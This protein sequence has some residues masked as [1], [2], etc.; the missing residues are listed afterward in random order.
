MTEKTDEGRRNFLKL[1][2]VGAPAA[3]AATTVATTEEA[4]A[5]TE[6]K[7]EGLRK[8]AHVKAYLESARF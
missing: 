1:A 5:A 7:G 8:T 3:A 2:A 4:E 6:S